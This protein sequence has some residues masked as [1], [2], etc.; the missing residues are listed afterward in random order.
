[1]HVR[2]WHMCA[3]KKRV[4]H[5][6]RVVVKILTTGASKPCKSLSVRLDYRWT[7]GKKVAKAPVIRYFYE[8]HVSKVL[9][10]PVVGYVVRIF[11]K[12]LCFDKWH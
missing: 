10:K 8:R 1:M 11:S 4:Q 2:V 9:E 12:H 5:S 3:H 6:Y 7:E